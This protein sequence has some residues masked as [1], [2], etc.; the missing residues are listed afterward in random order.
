MERGSVFVKYVALL[1]YTIPI[2]VHQNVSESS[3]MTFNVF[4]NSEF[5]ADL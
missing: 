2:E 1:M 5:S 4:V 3:T